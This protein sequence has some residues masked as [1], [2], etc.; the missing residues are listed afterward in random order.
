M[1]NYKLTNELVVDADNF[2]YPTIK[3]QIFVDK[4]Q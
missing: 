3:L 2:L 1:L 4:I